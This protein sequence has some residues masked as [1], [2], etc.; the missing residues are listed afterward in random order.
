MS[1]DVV[2]SFLTVRLPKLG[3]CRTVPA[4]PMYD[5]SVSSGTGEIVA[6]LPDW[7]A[8]WGN[9]GSRTFL[10]GDVNIHPRDVVSSLDI[11]FFPGEIPRL[12][13]LDR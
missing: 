11:L 2:P 12:L 10:W 3:P 9:D 5:I 8:S 13:C 1:S 7:V 6:R 4:F